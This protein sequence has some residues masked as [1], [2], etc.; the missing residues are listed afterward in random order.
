MFSA[1]TFGCLASESEAP[2]ESTIRFDELGRI[3][4]GPAGNEVPI[5][6]W[7]GAFSL[8]NGEPL[9]RFHT[10]PRS[11]EPCADTWTSTGAVIGGGAVWTPF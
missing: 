5:Q 9:W 8:D 2:W 1:N 7:V 6:G 11:G 4:V 10:M 3:I